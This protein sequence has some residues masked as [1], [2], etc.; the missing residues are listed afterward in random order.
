MFLLIPIIIALAAGCFLLALV[1]ETFAYEL[2]RVIEAAFDFA[3]YKA[4]L[5]AHRRASSAPR[6]QARYETSY[7]EASYSRAV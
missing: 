1:S 6:G 2:S 7:P 5:R 4:A 3:E